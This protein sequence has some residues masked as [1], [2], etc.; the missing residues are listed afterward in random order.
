VAVVGCGGGPPTVAL[1][2]GATPAAA[3]AALTSPGS[4]S[5]ARP[6][7]AAGTRH[8]AIITYLSIWPAGDRAE[9]SGSAAE[10]RTILAAYASPSYIEFM[11]DGMRAYWRQRELATGYMS[12][13]ILHAT[14]TTGR[15]GRQVATVVDC[16]DASHHRL[17]GAMTGQV[18]PRT[19]GPRQAW[20]QASLT[21][22]SGRWLVSQITHV[23][24]R[25]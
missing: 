10:A 12:D 9:R 5:P 14:V 4:S 3:H 15:G 17:T 18:I 23:S 8:G 2:K 16:Q 22:I 13:H 21:F 6:S 25:C 7:P 19:R 1:P 24:N 11:I 20:L